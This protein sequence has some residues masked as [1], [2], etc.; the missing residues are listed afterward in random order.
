MFNQNTFSD[1]KLFL[2]LGIANIILFLIVYIP[3]N[4]FNHSI[5][6]HPYFSWE[7]SIPFLKWMIIPY[8]SFNLLFLLPLFLL[9]RRS[10]KVLGVSFAISTIIAGI[11]F[12]LFPAQIGFQRLI[13]EG[14]T[15]PLYKYLFTFDNTTNLVPSLHVTYMILYFVSCVGLFKRK[16]T[17]ILFGL[18]SLLIISSTLFTHQ[19]HLLD[20]IT[21]VLLGVTVYRFVSN[22]LFQ[23]NSPHVQGR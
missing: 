14:F 21:G 5:Y 2:K 16:L 23:G 6:Y 18:V 13:P 22:S 17:Q 12:I 19:H 8:H 11:S 4:H 10:M 7:L 15:A 3:T 20:I 9:P 1:K